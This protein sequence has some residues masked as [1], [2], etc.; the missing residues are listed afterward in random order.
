MRNFIRIAVA[1]LLAFVGSL[2]PAH[3]GTI[4]MRPYFASDKS[5]L[6]LIWDEANGKSKTWYY[7]QAEKK[8]KP[9]QAKYQLPAKTGI[10]SNVMMAPYLGPDG[11]EIILVWNKKTGESVSWYF[12]NAKN[13][14]A[15]SEKKYQ[16]PKQKG[17]EIMMVPYVA[18]DGSEVILVWDAKTGKSTSW[19]FDKADDK[20]KKSEPGFQLPAKPL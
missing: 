12:D 6:V 4:H 2:T 15:R 16:V 17:K 11:S 9:S 3:A 18:K 19:Y 8:F 10:K 1:V 20:F 14:F 7:D 13:Q 5:E